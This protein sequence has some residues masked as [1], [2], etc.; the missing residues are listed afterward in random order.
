MS[1][2][3]E[4]YGY[5]LRIWNWQG[6]NKLAKIHE[7]I[8]AKNKD[9]ITFGPL[10]DTAYELTPYVTINGI[11]WLG[12]AKKVDVPKID[13]EPKVVASEPGKV[14]LSLGLPYK[15]SC[16]TLSCEWVVDDEAI[17]VENDTKIVI[18]GPIETSFRKN[19]NSVLFRYEM[20]TILVL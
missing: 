5:R 1:S 7:V 18:S 17:V 8:S 3:V 10:I 16:D 12:D 4:N 2:K 15:I 13:I 6:Y 20:P 9:L 11:S 14:V 19:V